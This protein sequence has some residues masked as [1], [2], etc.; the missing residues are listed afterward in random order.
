M[1]RRLRALLMPV[2]A[3]AIG[4]S[5]A[6]AAAAQAKFQLRWGHYL[7]DGPF[8]Q[9]EKDFAANIEKR[10]NGQ[11]KI[12][13]TFAE[14]LGKGT[15]LLMLAAR[16]GI[17]MTATA[18]GY[19]PDQLRYWRAFQSPLVFSDIN[20]VIKV[21][22]TVVEEF[23]A[24]RGEMDKIGVVWLFQQLQG[25]Y[26]LSGSSPSCASV[27]DLKG[28]KARTFGA[29]IPKAFSAIGAVPV[30]V[31]PVGVYEALKTGNLDY[32]FI[33]PANIQ[34]LKLNEVAKNHCGPVMAISG[35]NIT[36]GKR[37][38]ARLPA[39]IQKI[40]LE[41][42]KAT[43]RAYINWVSENERKALENIRAQ[44][45]NVIPIPAAELAK[46]SAAAPDF[47]AEWE[48]A[49]AAATGDAETPRKV[50]ARWRE[51]LGKK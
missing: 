35:H 16:G 33:N 2:L 4:L 42:A 21:L 8:L 9:L 19:N 50:A 28:K 32:S 23:P 12:E 11:V 25:E 3:G 31:P 20:Q 51:L 6:G 22:E 7:P 38:W 40:F 14:G 39:D 27:A 48:K 43:Q 41:E 37:T 49:T 13:I 29:D 47:L 5:I 10:T 44:G 17:D 26:F 36:I 46:W 18:P 24:Y 45:G 1:K 34:A 30:T 15:E